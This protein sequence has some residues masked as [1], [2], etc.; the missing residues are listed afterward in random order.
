MLETK[1]LE[2]DLEKIKLDIERL[3]LSVET[4][5][6][7][8]VIKADKEKN[9]EI[10]DEKKEGDLEVPEVLEVPEDAD[11]PELEPDFEDLVATELQYISSEVTKAQAEIEDL[12]ERV[13]SLGT[14][15]EEGTEEEPE[16]DVENY[17]QGIVGGAGVVISSQP[18]GIYQI[19][20]Y[21]TELEKHT[22]TIT[23]SE[24]PPSSNDTVDVTTG[25]W[26]YEEERIEI[27]AASGLGRV[28]KPY[29]VAELTK[30]G[31]VGEVV[32]QAGMP[33]DDEFRLLATL[34]YDNNDNN[35]L[36]SITYNHFADIYSRKINYESF[37][38]TVNENGTACDIS[39]GSWTRNGTKTS[40]SAENIGSKSKS[41]IVARITTYDNK[42]PL[43]S[44]NLEIE[45]QESAPSGDDWH[46]QRLLCEIKWNASGEEIDYFVIHHAGDIKDF[47]AMG[48]VDF[49]S[50][51]EKQA[52]PHSST[53]ETDSKN[54]FLRLK[55]SDK[56]A[57]KDKF[58]KLDDNNNLVWTSVETTDEK[59]KASSS[60]DTAGYLDAK[61]AKSVTVSAN[62]LQLVGDVAAPGN[63]YYYGTDTGGTKTFHELDASAVLPDG[64]TKYEALTWDDAVAGEWA[65]GWIKGHN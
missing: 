35:K 45:S 23:K 53:I 40:A 47:I 19:S 20:A 17:V 14:K 46:G 41:F 42:N 5:D 54:K 25:F 33:N 44:A 51:T 31:T 60:D 63:S 7:L 55:D 57:S 27:P 18:N 59:V 32:A 50:V 38:P 36:K 62:K 43:T 21:E 65:P 11:K 48:D 61:V 9:K 24:D 8:N 29:I 52:N 58:A 64:N 49:E 16:G 30:G 10:K 22:F 28:D 39:E 34:E 6:N 13:F 2:S 15:T 1:Q 3:Q 4:I 26:V 56:Y 12:Q 37:Y